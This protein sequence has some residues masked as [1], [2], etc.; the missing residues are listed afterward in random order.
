MAGLLKI[1]AVGLVVIAAVTWCE[2]DEA[3]KAAEPAKPQVA[4][5]EAENAFHKFF[6][7]NPKFW[8]TQ[9]ATAGGCSWYK[10]YTLTEKEVTL[11]ESYS[12]GQQCRSHYHT[13]TFGGND[14]MFSQSDVV[15]VAQF[16]DMVY[17]N[18]TCAVVKGAQWGQ[19]E[20]KDNKTKSCGTRNGQELD[21]FPPE[22]CCYRN[23]STKLS[24]SPMAKWLRRVG[25]EPEP[26]YCS[27]G[28]FHVIYV[29][30]S[31]KNEVPSD[32]IKE[33][34]ERTN[35]KEG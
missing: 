6:Q 34:Q 18:K 21:P 15:G 29:T 20:D 32:C 25:D 16:Y 3:P 23:D 12:L 10:N 22:P 26:F 5:G 28:T 9:K 17:I 7:G 8:V 2:G 13:Y 33:Y 4:E 27:R 11:E 19:R 31:M 24:E 1:V 14:R 30:D 35:R